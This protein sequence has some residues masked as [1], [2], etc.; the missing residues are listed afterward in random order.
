MAGFDAISPGWGPRWPGRRARQQHLLRGLRIGDAVRGRRA[1]AGQRG[2]VLAVPASPRRPGIR[3]ALA[4]HEACDA[5]LRSADV[6]HHPGDVPERF[7]DH[8]PERHAQTRRLRCTRDADARGGGWPRRA[9][10]PARREEE[11]IM[12]AAELFVA[13]HWTAR[14]SALLFATALIVPLFLHTQRLR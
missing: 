5:G 14:V 8:T 6:R 11:P 1:H 10:H 4:P 12:N 2:A 7:L 3:R 13:V 9:H